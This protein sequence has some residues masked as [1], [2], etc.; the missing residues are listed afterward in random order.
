MFTNQT[1]QRF[2]PLKLSSGSDLITNVAM[3]NILRDSTKAFERARQE[4]RERNK[5]IGL[6]E[7]ET[8]VCYLAEIIN[9]YV[10]SKI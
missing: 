10:V 8:G 2:P 1:E 4:K 7:I 6:T 5:K 3:K 9:Q